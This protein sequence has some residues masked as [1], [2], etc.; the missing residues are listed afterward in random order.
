MLNYPRYYIVKIYIN[1]LFLLSHLTLFI[2][3]L[4]LIIARPQF[5]E[6]ILKVI[7]SDIDSFLS[8]IIK[9][10]LMTRSVT[11]LPRHADIV[12]VIAVLQLLQKVTHV[13]VRILLVQ[14]W[15]W[16]VTVIRW[17]RNQV[18]LHRFVQ[19]LH[20]LLLLALRNAYQLINIVNFLFLV[21]K[22]WLFLQLCL[23][24]IF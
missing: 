22:V 7:I 9:K 23:A 15:K 2:N 16:N 17:C 10:P 5:H 4:I 20:F 8:M 13:M 12:F 14:L 6:K 18:D 3:L 1:H 19:I 11:L 21:A 24:L